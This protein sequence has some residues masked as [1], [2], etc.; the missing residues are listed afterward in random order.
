MFAIF[1]NTLWLT[2]LALQL[3]TC[4]VQ[5]G[6]IP[7]RSPSLSA[8][9]QRDAFSDQD[10]QNNEGEN[11]GRPNVPNGASLVSLPITSSASL[12]TYWTANPNNATATIAYIM[13]HGK[14]RN[15]GD[16]WT[17]MNEVLQQAAANK[18][19]GAVATSIVTAPQFYS[20]RLNS[21]Q[22]T[23]KQLAFADTNVWQ[24][25]EAAVRPA[26]TNVTSLDAL[27]TLLTEFSTTSRYPNM[28][29]ITFI[30]H[31]G[32]GQLISRYAVVG[33]GLPSGSK[34][35]LRYVVGDPS[36]NPYFTLDRPLQDPSVANKAS[37]PLFNRWRY[38]FD[39][40][41]GTTAA[42][43]LTPQEYFARLASRDVR[44]VVGYQDTDGDGD[45]TCM[46]KLQGGAARR[47]RNLSWWRYINTLAGTNQ[48]L[49]GFP[50]ALPGMVSW[51]NL[52]KG[53]LNH[54]LTVVY[55]A[56]H[57]AE[58]VY[59]SME[60]TSALF[61][62]SANVQLG[63]RPQGWRNVSSINHSTNGSSTG[64][65]PTSAASIT[66]MPP[67]QAA[68]LLVACLLATGALVLL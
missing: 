58:K 44:W 49:T 11:H 60:G 8:W 29:Q 63:W 64:S 19:A 51:S 68:T 66:L 46:A 5:A 27:D 6:S 36:S 22:Y 17:I 37:C 38:G 67:A 24:A 3:L 56:D 30:G 31:G 18:H 4:D 40:F 35:Q 9:Q 20:A 28:K 43:P 59:T 54:R 61:D 23:S 25:G 33:A 65:P 10:P 21:G 1:S 32:G 57:S 47:D 7:V 12:A 16:Y 15:G 55:D 50:G 48:D 26:G 52:T 39:C 34:I 42:G 41:S 45:N 53:S 13:M 62:D 2:L 14:L